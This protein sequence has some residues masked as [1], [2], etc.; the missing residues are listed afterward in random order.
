MHRSLLPLALTACATPATFAVQDAGSLEDVYGRV[1]GAVVTLHTKTTGVS[2]EVPGMAVTEEGVGSGTLI[3]AT[4]VLTAAHVVQTADKVA[5]Q[6]FDGTL[7]PARV[8]S[9]DPLADLALVELLGQPPAEVRPVGL[10]DSSRA[11]IGSPVFVVGAPLGISHTLT[12][13]VLSARRLAPSLLGDAARVEVFQTDAAINPGN[14]GGPLFDMDGHVIGVVSYIVSQSGGHEGLGFAVTSDTARQRLLERMPLW[15]GMDFVLLRE[16]SSQI[17]NLPD[18]R[19]GLLVQHVAEGSP[20]QRLGLRGGDVPATVGGHAMLLGGDV[21]LEV[22]G[23]EVTG[24]GSSREVKERVQALGRE[25][26]LTL[27]V[28]RG[29]RLVRLRAPMGDLR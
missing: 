10:G 16:R 24:L 2:F 8:V 6:F 22:L 14:S 11:R 28:L 12:V 27:T 1:H 9:S 29:G 21:I 26:Q 17:L 3:S 5:V 7:V 23:V 20:A 15:T 19:P 18:G 4:Q 13:G 25:E